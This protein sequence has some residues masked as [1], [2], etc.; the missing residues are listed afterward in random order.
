MKTL[1]EF[2]SEAISS[3][4]VLVI[5][6]ATKSGK[7]GQP[8]LMYKPAQIIRALNK[9]VSPEAKKALQ[10]AYVDGNTSIVNKGTSKTMA[11][12]KLNQTFADLTKAVEAW[13]KENIELFAPKAPKP[14]IDLQSPVRAIITA[15]N[16]QA[17]EIKKYVHNA[18]AGVKVRIMSRKTGAKVY[19][20]V[21]DESL[22]N[23]AVKKAKEIIE[24]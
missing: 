8:T 1:K 14:T 21:K 11:S 20:D 15:S 6:K 13:T 17:T 10:G 18:R 5:N 22:L 19:I 23:D 2:L 12:F 16:E 9:V 3:K 4:D 24:K 7:D